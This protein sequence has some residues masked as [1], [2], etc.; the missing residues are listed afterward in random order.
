M[1]A[2]LHVLR[3]RCAAAFAI[4]A[5]IAA[6]LSFFVLTSAASA[7][8]DVPTSSFAIVPAES[9]PSCRY[10]AAALGVSDR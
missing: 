3:G 8:S 4:I 2:S 10:G 6:A 9:G 1:F 5:A 7:E